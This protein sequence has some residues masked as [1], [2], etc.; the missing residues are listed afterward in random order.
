MFRTISS[1]KVKPD[2]FLKP[3]SVKVWYVILAMIGVVTTILI[4]FLKLENIGISPTEIYG[5]SV[6]L[7]IGALSQQGIGLIK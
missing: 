7:T 2:Q 6:L 5:L 1:T 4:I 3:L